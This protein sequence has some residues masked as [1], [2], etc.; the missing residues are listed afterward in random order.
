MSFDFNGYLS[1]TSSL[2]QRQRSI[3]ATV[4]ASRI[5]DKPVLSVSFLRRGENIDPQDV[6]IEY[7]DF[8]RDAEDESGDAEL[9]KGTLFG[10]QGHDTIEDL[11]VEPM[12]TF[13]HDD[14]EFTITFVNRNTIGQIQAFFEAV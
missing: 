1:Q 5:A 4:Q 13:I 8:T 10:V 2:V 7:D 11:D 14:K 12:D 6:R 3:R 9:V